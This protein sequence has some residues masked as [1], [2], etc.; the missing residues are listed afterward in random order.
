MVNPIK[1]NICLWISAEL[2]PES[3]QLV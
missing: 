1:L 2:S 3:L